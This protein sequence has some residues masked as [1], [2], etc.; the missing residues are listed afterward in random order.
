MR[1][2][3]FILLLIINCASTEAQFIQIPTNTTEILKNIVILDGTMF[4]QNYGSLFLRTDDSFNTFVKM[5][6]PSDTTYINKL[7]SINNKL[8]LISSDFNSDQTQ[9][10]SSNDKGNNWVKT[11]DTIGFNT[12]DYIMFDSLNGATLSGFYNIYTI[13]NAGLNWTYQPTSSMGGFFIKKYS[14]SF[15]IWTSPERVYGTYNRF[16]TS[17]NKYCTYLLNPWMHL[18]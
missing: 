18:F 11:F 13:S 2:I 17:I 5:T 3:L 1:K 7:R 9:F 16:N 4:V 8:F 15:S 10:W 6:I 14:D 12:D